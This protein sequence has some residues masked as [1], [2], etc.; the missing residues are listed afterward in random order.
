MSARSELVVLGRVVRNTAHWAGKII[1]TTSEVVPYDVIK[2]TFAGDVIE[3]SYLGG[4]VGVINQKVTHEAT[5]AE[6]ELAVLFLAGAEKGG[7]FAPGTKRIVE[8]QG[9]IQL[10]PPGFSET[11]F[12]YDRRLQQDIQHITNRIVRGG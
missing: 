1:V 9:K 12:K 4:T 3:V 7:P 2:G 6:G 10:L 5:L 11:R 8:E